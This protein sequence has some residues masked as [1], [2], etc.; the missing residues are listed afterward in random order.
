MSSQ[1]IAKM[2]AKDCVW[3]LQHL[4]VEGRL[5]RTKVRLL[6]TILEESQS[7]SGLRW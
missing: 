6:D 7:D 4:W 2:E 5:F 1:C 3:L